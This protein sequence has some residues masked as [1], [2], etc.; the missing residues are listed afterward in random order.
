MVNQL[1]QIADTDHGIGDGIPIEQVR[2]LLEENVH[3]LLVELLLAGIGIENDLFHPNQ[4][5]Q[6]P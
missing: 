6:C 1:F 5:A 3:I 4:I 2:L